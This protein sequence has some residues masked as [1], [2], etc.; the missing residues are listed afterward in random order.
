MKTASEALARTVLLARDLV[1]EAVSDD[2]I[3]ARLR[4]TRVVIVADEENLGTIGGQS[5]V[6]TLVTH[7]LALGA[8]VDLLFPNV[9]IIGHQPPLRG[10]CVVDA[11]EEFASD[12]MPEATARAPSRIA[13]PSIIF[14]VGST[15]ARDLRGESWRLTGT[16]GRGALVPAADD[17]APFPNYPM[18]AL[19][20]AN[21][22]AAEVFKFA[23]R[24]LV[25]PR[26]SDLVAPSLRSSVRLLDD[27]FVDAPRTLGR[28]DCIS[29]GAVVQAA[30]HALLRIPGLSGDLRVLEP[31]RLDLTNLNR[32]L[33]VRASLVG[34][35]KSECLEACSTPALRIRGVPMAF[36]A[37][38]LGTI[39]PLASRVLVGTDAVPPRW[40]AQELEPQWLAIGATTHYQAL[41]SDHTKDSA[42]ARCLHPGDDGVRAEIPTVG[43]VS[44]WAG[45]LLAAKVLEHVSGRPQTSGAA[46][47]LGS[48]RPDGPRARLDYEVQPAPNCSRC[49]RA[50]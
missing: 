19:A 49:R 34:Q 44:Y 24:P 6:V 5:A 46:T 23:M 12:F 39:S 18:G 1:H 22:A 7:A 27:S 21:L 47:L 20:A 41:V 30:A 43:F 8:D 40:L 42:C 32:Y 10:S 17:S 11:L 31:D 50:A 25:E 15:R 16:A 14:Y 26:L 36:T 37:E 28:V 45:L 4:R 38:T 35:L 2:A 33:L 9:P 3:V 13:T 29:G 48:L